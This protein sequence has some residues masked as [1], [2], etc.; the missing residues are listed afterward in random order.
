M[1]AVVRTSYAVPT[2]A[3]V[4]TVHGWRLACGSVV[5][6][7]LL[8]GGFRDD[9]WCVGDPVSGAHIT[10]GH[11]M[12]EAVARYRALVRKLGPAWPAELAKARTKARAVILSLHRWHG[13]PR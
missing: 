13:V 10:T 3:G 5:H 8:W 7:Q 9:A 12:G 6:R 2:R 4:E 11:T 1:A